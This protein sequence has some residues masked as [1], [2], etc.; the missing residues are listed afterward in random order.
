[1]YYQQNLEAGFATR[2]IR[3]NGA[4]DWHVHENRLLWGRME[5]PR[6]VL[7]L[8]TVDGTSITESDSMTLHFSHPLPNGTCRRYVQIIPGGDFLMT[9]VLIQDTGKR[10]HKLKRISAGGSVLWS[11]NLKGTMTRPV[12]GKENIYFVRASSLKDGVRT[13]K[14][15]FA[16][17]KICDG[18][19]IFDVPI[20]PGTRI[21]KKML[22]YD[23]SLLLTGNERLVSWGKIT[24]S[25]VYIFSTS[26]GQV[27]Y[28]VHQPRSFS[29]LLQSVGSSTYTAGF[30]HTGERTTIL[31]SYD[32]ASNSFS[33]VQDYQVDGGLTDDPPFVIF[34]G[35]RSIFLR[36]LHS[37]AG[38]K[39]GRTNH[40][41]QL[42]ILPA[43]QALDSESESS[44]S[45]IPITL[46]G[47]SKADGKR[48]DLEFE[49]PWTFKEGDFYGMMNDYLV[50]HSRELESLV[51]VDFWPEW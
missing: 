47:L 9:T 28:T 42:A 10:A 8:R 13:C 35:D 34:D 50:Y 22:D 31:S 2:A 39:G 43:A 11:L 37:R 24:R 1:M 51:L 46:P 29:P 19:I 48:R 3:C 18:S 14:M 27:L 33:E 41:A 30:W 5:E 38:Y 20:P 36:V 26:T 16:K 49:L 6:L 23:G 25:E 45:T 12:I 17:R 4:S 15:F 7:D 40:F 21:R 44:D 32:E